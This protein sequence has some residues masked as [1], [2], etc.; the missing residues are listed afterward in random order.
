MSTKWYISNTLSDMYR[1][2]SLVDNHF[3]IPRNPETKL[4]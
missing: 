3:D 2:P 4:G 1:N